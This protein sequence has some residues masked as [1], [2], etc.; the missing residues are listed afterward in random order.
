[1]SDPTDPKMVGELKILGFSNYLH[2][3]DDD[4]ILAIGQ[5]AD[6][7]GGTIG[8]QIAL[9]YVS[10]FADPTLDTRDIA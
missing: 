10:D 3:I 4:S 6:E 2:P 7:K 8:L 9:F 1:M 5:D